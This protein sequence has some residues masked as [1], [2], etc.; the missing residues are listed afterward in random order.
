MAWSI[1][2]LECGVLGATQP[3]RFD[4]SA[5]ETAENVQQSIDRLHHFLNLW[6]RR[7]FA[8]AVAQASSR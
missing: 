6:N 7:A 3:P 5:P 8:T 4:F 2:N 1:L